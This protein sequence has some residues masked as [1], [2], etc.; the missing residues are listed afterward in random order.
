MFTTENSQKYVEMLNEESYLLDAQT[1]FEGNF[2][3]Q[4]DG[5]RLHTA[6][7]SIESITKVC[8]LVTNWPPNSPDI[9]VIEMVW[10]VMD[11]I[12]SF[13][14]PTNKSELIDA[15]KIA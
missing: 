8:D 10:A 14:H 7:V 1:N 2:A 9:N 11:D 5:A 4:Q 12:I 15:I 6:K 3:F 13:Y